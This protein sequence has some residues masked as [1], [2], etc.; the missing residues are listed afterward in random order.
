MRH[1][2]TPKVSIATQR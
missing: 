1:H 2:E